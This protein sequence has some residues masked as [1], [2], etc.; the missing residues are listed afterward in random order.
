MKKL[1][2]C[3]I[4]F[5]ALMAL[6]AFAADYYVDGDAG[7]D[8]TGLG[9]ATAP[10]Q[11]VTKAVS[12]MSGGD[13]VYCKGT[14]I[15]SVT[16]D[17]T[18]SGTADNPTVFTSWEGSTGII[19]GNSAAI[20]MQVSGDYITIQ[21]LSI[22][23]GTSYSLI[24]V[25]NYNYI[26]EN[27]F[28]SSSGIATSVSV[29][30]QSGTNAI[31]SHNTVFGDGDDNFGVYL[32]A[33]PN[34]LIEN[35][36]VYGFNKFGVALEQGCTDSVV[37]NNIIYNI[38]SADV[39]T[40]PAALIIADDHD[41]QIINNTFY[42]TYNATVNFPAI[43]LTELG[44]A[45]TYDITIKNNIF[46]TA[47]IGVYA[48]S[49]S[50]TGSNCDYNDYYNITTHGSVDGT[51]Y[52][53]FAEWQGYST[54]DVHSLNSDPLFVSTATG[55]LDSHLQGTSPAIDA[56]IDIS[57]LTTDYDNETRPY[58]ITDI[59]ADERPVLS[60]TPNNL[61]AVPSVKNADISWEMDSS[62]AVTSYN[63]K[64][65][66]LDDLSDGVVGSL[67]SADTSLN[68]AGL[69]PAQKYYYAVQAIYATDYQEYISDYS[70][71]ASFYTYPKKVTEVKV[72]EAKITSTSARIKW[73]KQNRVTGYTVKLMDKDKHL[74]KYFSVDSGDHATEIT[75]LN[76]DKKYKI[77]VRSEN[78][79]G[80][81]IYVSKWSKIKTFRTAN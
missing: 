58:N 14:I 27:T 8:L 33:S 24:S 79:V 81:T 59:G 25:G 69:K 46:H 9:T 55:A 54:N 45:Q 36:T 38:G 72:P 20:T 32:H 39:Y 17:A 12:V 7:N 5:S 19:D 47:N 37:K 42:N 52:A 2:L 34:A 77:K 13:T 63:V 80:Q 66:K 68:N 26:H 1:L 30:M 67:N 40:W 74:I 50:F 10:Y 70:S 57:G 48:D 71:I 60:V 49:G 76:S 56:G 75:N 28:F 65:G 29:Y 21:G 4:I 15:D 43:R 31:F 3:G 78:K 6:P 35:N 41:I 62:Y 22:G 51:N 61:H 16:I 44:I 11:T 73:K 18:K 23:N 64:I 53:T